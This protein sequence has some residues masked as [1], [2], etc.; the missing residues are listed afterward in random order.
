M[1]CICWDCFVDYPA[2]SARHRAPVGVST[3]VAVPEKTQGGEDADR[4]YHGFRAD[5]DEW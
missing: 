2:F 4:Q 5:E 1:N 3:N